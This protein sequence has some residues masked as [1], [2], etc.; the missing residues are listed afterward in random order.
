MLNFNSIMLGTDNL[1]EMVEF[2]NKVLGKPTMEDG[3]YTGWLVGS[4]WFSIGEHSEVGGKSKE[5]A[6]CMWFFETADVKGEFERIQEIGA[7]V[8]REPYKPSP[9]DDMMLATLADP[10]GNYFQLASPWEDGDT[11]D[12]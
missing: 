7:E 1:K 8:I 2:Y 6:R 12:K 4:G 9:G 3:G 10:D 11:K 5:P